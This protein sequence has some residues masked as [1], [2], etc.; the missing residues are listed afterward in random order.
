MPSHMRNLTLASAKHLLSQGHLTPAHH[1][2]I[3]ASVKFPKM[4]M[5]QAGKPPKVPG[6]GALAKNIA[7]PLPQPGL[8][9]T[10]PG[11]NTSMAPPGMPPDQED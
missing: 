11:L 4:K 8:A 1:A 9:A 3:V 10:I 2:K 7:T 6:F 5:P